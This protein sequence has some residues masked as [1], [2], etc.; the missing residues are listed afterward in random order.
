VGVVDGDL[1][2]VARPAQGELATGDGV[3]EEELATAVPPACRDTRLRGLQDVLRGPGDVERAA[4]E[5]DENDG[6]A[7]SGDASNNF[8]CSP[9]RSSEEREAASPLM[10]WTSPRVRMVRSS[11]GEGEACRTRTSPSSP[12]AKSRT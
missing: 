11:C 2:D 5:E 7:E 6:L 10:S 8:S 4:V 3:A 12:L 9:G 1:A